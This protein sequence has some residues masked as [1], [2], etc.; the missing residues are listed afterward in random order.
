MFVALA[1]AAVLGLGW[2]AWTVSA[3]SAVPLNLWLPAYAGWFGAGMALAT[4]TTADP[5]WGPV[6]VLNDLGSSLATCWAGAAALF[7]I[8]TSRVAGPESLV[9]PTVGQ[10]VTKNVLYLGIAT[11]LLLPLVF[12]DQ[13][14]GRVR[15][16]LSS[17]QSRFLGEISYG[18]FLLHV[19]VLA[20]AYHALGLRPFSGNIVL[21]LM[22]TW[23]SAAALA[24]VVYLLLERPLR[25]WRGL[26]TD[27]PSRDEGSSTVATTAVRATS[28]SV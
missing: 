5:T 25:R 26:V 18:M 1:V 10:S 28:A 8:A 24:T 19:V 21:V 7:W 9:F 17:A 20:W 13:S 4:L 16:I 6:R 14:Q 3:P 23:L 22:G 15:T 27:R 12:G 11:L 2:I